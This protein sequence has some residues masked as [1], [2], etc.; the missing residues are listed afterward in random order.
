[1]LRC[2]RGARSYIDGV[3]NAA[4]GNADFSREYGWNTVPVTPG[5]HELVVILHVRN[6]QSYIQ[7]PWKL[8]FRCEKGHTCEFQS[9]DDYGKQLKVVDLTTDQTMLIR[10]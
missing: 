8:S 5:V 3:D 4:I 10:G 1:M 6:G 2:S 9:N 7:D